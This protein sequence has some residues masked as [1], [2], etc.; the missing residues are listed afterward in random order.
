MSTGGGE[1]GTAGYNLSQPGNVVLTLGDNQG[2]IRDL[3]FA[4]TA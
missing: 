1:G 3:A 4:R 2:T